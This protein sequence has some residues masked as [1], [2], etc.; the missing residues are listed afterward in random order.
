MTSGYHQVRVDQESQNLLSITT[1]MG[2][3][4]YTILAQGISSA[5]DIFNLLTDGDLRINS[6][7][8]IKNMDNVL[9]FSETLEG[10]KK[11][12]EIFLDMCKKKTSS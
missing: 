5:S 1:P 8:A 12:L 2:R 10:L 6:L 11:E 4:R 3:Y 9:L 7:N